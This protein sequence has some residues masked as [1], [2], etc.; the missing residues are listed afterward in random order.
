M[1][2]LN[3]RPFSCVFVT[4]RPGL[5]ESEPRRSDLHRVFGHPQEPGHSPVQSSLPG[6]GRMAAGAHQGDVGHRQRA[7]Q[8]RVGGQRSGKPQT[9][10]GRQQV[11]NTHCTSVCI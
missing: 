4:V 6:P 1:S 5:G 2:N 11:G 7:G 10:T 3:V 8:R 9:R